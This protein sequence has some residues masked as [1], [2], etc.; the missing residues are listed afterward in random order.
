M[1]QTAHGRWEARSKERKARAYWSTH[2][3]AVAGLT[4]AGQVATAASEASW[5]VSALLPRFVRCARSS[6][7]LVSTCM[8]IGQGKPFAVSLGVGAPAAGAL[9]G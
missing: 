9:L 4:G 5:H 3:R 8:Q 7:A 1:A 6:S 2:W